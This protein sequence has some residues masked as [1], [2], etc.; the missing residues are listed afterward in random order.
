MAKVYSKNSSKQSA[1]GLRIFHLGNCGCCWVLWKLWR[2]GRSHVQQCRLS[3]LLYGPYNTVSMAD[4]CSLSWLKSMVCLVLCTDWSTSCGMLSA[5]AKQIGVPLAVTSLRWN[6]EFL[7]TLLW[8][9]PLH[10][11]NTISARLFSFCGKL[12]GL[13][14][15]QL[16]TIIIIN[17]HWVYTYYA[18]IYI[19]PLT[20]LLRSYLAHIAIPYLPLTHKS[21]SS[22]VFIRSMLW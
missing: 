3:P 21:H 2:Q 1:P 6:N 12:I 18:N 20:H 8:Y 15:H 22:K 4:K 10:L 5:E 13:I 17:H 7:T 14:F 16:L 11:V 9:T 19:Q